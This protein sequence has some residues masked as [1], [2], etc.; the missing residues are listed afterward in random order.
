M[1]GR[2]QVAFGEAGEGPEYF[3]FFCE[4]STM[5][6]FVKALRLGPAVKT[7]VTNRAVMQQ[8]HLNTPTPRAQS[9]AQAIFTLEW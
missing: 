8:A 5:A 9:K 2:G 1:L 6:L 3:E 7:Q 4:K